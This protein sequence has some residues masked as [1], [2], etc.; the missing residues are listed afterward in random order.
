[1]RIKK[2]FIPDLW[3]EYQTSGQPRNPYIKKGDF[4]KVLDINELLT[5]GNIDRPSDT[6]KL[7]AAGRVL[8]IIGSTLI[9][10]D[11]WYHIALLNDT[12]TISLTDADIEFVLRREDKHDVD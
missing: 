6:Q 12:H 4:V 3:F 1:M 8:Q 9:A 10:T 2:L 7:L 11:L 5:S